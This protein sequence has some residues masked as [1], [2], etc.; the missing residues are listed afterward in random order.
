MILNESNIG[1]NEFFVELD[2][3]CRVSSQTLKDI[4]VYI[5]FVPHYQ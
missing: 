4:S 3:P 1:S 2:S 5:D